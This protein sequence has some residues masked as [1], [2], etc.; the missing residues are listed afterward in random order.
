MRVLVVTNMYPSDEFPAL[1]TF[2]KD[3]AGALR[4]RGIQIE[5]LLMKGPKKDRT[6][7]VRG[8]VDVLGQVRSRRYDLIHAHYVFSGIIARVQ[9]R[10]PLLVS[11]HGGRE[12]VGWQGILCKMLAPL[13]DAVTVTSQVH[14]K[15]LGRR[16]AHVIPCGV[17]FELFRP[18]SQCTARHELGL[19]QDR[20]LALFVA[21]LRPEKRHDIA[22]KA[23]NLLQER[24]ENIELLTV[25]GH[26]HNTIPKYLNAGDV[27]LL[28]SEHEGSPVVIKEAMAC[29]VPIVSVDVGDVREVIG[30]TAGCYVC[31]RSAED[32]AEK[33]AKVLRTTQ[34]TEGRQ[35]I[36]HL[37]VGFLADQLVGVYESL[38][39]KHARTVSQARRV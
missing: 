16:D 13:V 5:V 15:A 24:G 3:Q 25:T 34:R 18:V 23:I 7:Y 35:A 31:Q 27:L 14:K 4:V 21:E 30:A 17:D 26:P 33:V 12:M 38:L 39:Q 1:G 9:T 2:V 22:Q 20:R 11:F 19:P 29:N 6:K 10:Y 28:T 32:V 8:A 37:E 36:R